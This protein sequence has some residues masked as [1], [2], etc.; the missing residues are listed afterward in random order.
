MSHGG[1]AYVQWGWRIRP[2]GVAYTSNGGGVYVQWGW[3]IHPKV[4]KW[5]ISPKGRSFT[6]YRLLKIEMKIKFMFKNFTALWTY[7]PLLHL[8]MYTPPPLDVYATPIG[9][10]RHPHWTY[11]PPPLDVCATPMGHIRTLHILSV[12]L[13]M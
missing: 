9:R 13:C 5:R 2:M 3:R 1:G 11:T 7:T 6:W 4:Q 12:H 8:W 10:I